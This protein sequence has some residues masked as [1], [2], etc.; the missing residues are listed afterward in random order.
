L[1]LR[2]LA[3]YPNAEGYSR[4]PTGMA[5]IVT[6]LS[7][8]GHQLEVF[9]TTFMTGTNIDNSIRENAQLVKPTQADY[10]YENMDEQQI[11]ESFGQTV[12]GFDPDLLIVTLIEDNYRFAHSLMKTA[13]STKPSL[14]ILAGGPTPSA[15]PDVIVENPYVD[16]V[17]QGEGEES[18]LEFC[19]CME[20]GQ[21]S[22]GILNLWYKNRGQVMHNPLRPF[23]DM[24]TVPSQDFS[25][26]DERHLMKPYDGRI[27]RTGYVETSRG[28]P[29]NCTYCVNHAIRKSLRDC[30]RY[31]R[32]KDFALVIDEVKQQKE[33]LRIERVIFCDDN[34][35][36]CQDEDVRIFSDLWKKNIGLPYWITTSAEYV[37]RK[38]LSFLKDS[39]C[40]GIGLGVEAGGEW[41][42]R[43][44]LLRMVTNE[45]L[46]DAFHLIHDFEIRTT[47]NFM[48]GFPGEY[49]VDVFE[50]I[51]LMKKLE[52]R[53]F[54]ISFVSPYIGTKIHVLAKTLGLI[55]IEDV[56]GFRGMARSVS[57]RG[58]P[59]IRNPYMSEDRLVQLYYDAMAYVKGTRPIP[60][61]FL[62]PAPGADHL[63]SPRGELSSR[64]RE[65]ISQ[66]HE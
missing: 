23:V 65:I 18:A 19:E 28:C 60:D 64:E 6:L 41:F 42:R 59:S 27:Y 36:L 34:F 62:A 30:G 5:I 37:N 8:A 51:K 32:R 3:L 54:D 11:R 25:F 13:K 38:K 48:I 47:A 12:R 9:D 2:I 44:I 24:N 39:G 7:R 35:L 49:E 14:I 16:Y 52:P 1:K 55:D 50:S 15:A 57:F 33:H 56:P 22:E 63:A 40:D 66:I 45:K 4:I 46:I 29:H 21:A 26:W 10:G 53:S 20:R 61:Q 17:I 31:Y 58:R 43:N